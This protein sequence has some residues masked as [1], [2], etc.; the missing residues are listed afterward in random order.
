[1]RV[2]Y[3]VLVLVLCFLGAAAQTKVV[4]EKYDE[5]YEKFNSDV[6]RVLHLKKEKESPGHFSYKKG[7][8]IDYHCYED[9]RI[10]S[11]TIAGPVKEMNKLYTTFYSKNIKKKSLIKNDEWV[12]IQTDQKD[13]T[14][15]TKNKTSQIIIQAIIY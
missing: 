13:Q 7:I 8:T 15:Q 11:V 14:D 1:M 10:I 3:F 2:V 12:R 4:H 6:V 9:T 5:V